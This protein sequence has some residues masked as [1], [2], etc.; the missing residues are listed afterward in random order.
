MT[1]AQTEQHRKQCEARTVLSW[2]L[3]D[4]RAH[5]DLVEKRRGIPGRRELE[6]E[7][8]RQFNARKA[9]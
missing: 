1:P 5:L 8:I 3:N 6:A 4:R 2:P 7:M 9:A